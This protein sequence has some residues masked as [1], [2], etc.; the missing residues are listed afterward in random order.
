MLNFD[1]QTSIFQF[2]K[3]YSIPTRV[4]KLKVAPNMADPISIKDSRQ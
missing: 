4:T 2:S 1:F 3:K